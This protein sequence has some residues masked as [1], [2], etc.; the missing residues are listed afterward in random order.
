MPVTRRNP[1]TSLQASLTTGA[2][3]LGR[4]IPLPGLPLLDKSFYKI[5]K[6]FQNLHVNLVPSCNPV[7][8]LT[9]LPNLLDSLEEL[10]FVIEEPGCVFSD[11]RWLG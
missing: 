6:I 9:Y 11:A 2:P 3:R 1:R 10:L 5:H 8:Q 7:K 4:F